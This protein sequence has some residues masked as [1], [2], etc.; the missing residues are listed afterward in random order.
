METK[1]NYVVVGLFV[2]LLSTAM[3]AF[4]LWLSTGNR[5]NKVYDIYVAYMNESVAG[6]NLNAPVKYRG[7]NVGV[8]RRIS[9]DKTNPEKVKLEFKIEKGTPISEDTIAILK[10]QGLTGI[11]YVELTGGGKNSPLLIPAESAPYT[12]IK[13]GLSLLG[14]LDMGVSGLLV[15]V[16]KTAE[17]LNLLLDEA[18]R[19]AFK[20]TLAN[21]ATISGTLASR[22]SELDKAVV[23]SAQAMENAAKISTQLPALIERVQHSAEAIDKLAKEATRTSTSVRKAFDSVGP[24]AKRFAEDGLPELERMIVEMRELSVSMQRVTSQIEHDP[25][26]LLRGREARQPGPGE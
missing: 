23:N 8:V 25:S 5:Y 17:N 1:V 18:N 13:T 4:V 2:L 7:V 10:S 15:N 20:Q 11:A 21:I 16:N 24:E 22:K 19:K 6:L 14:R 9:L 12:E 3:I 26:V